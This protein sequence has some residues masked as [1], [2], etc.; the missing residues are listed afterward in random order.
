MC[1]SPGTLTNEGNSILIHIP[2]AIVSSFNGS[3]SHDGKLQEM[4]R[5][6]RHRRA[7]IMTHLGSKLASG[8][9]ILIDDWLIS[10]FMGIGCG[11]LEVFDSSSITLYWLVLVSQETF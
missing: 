3:V 9:L 1:L 5:L 11:W 2:I 10:S 8:S 7:R 4:R 6:L